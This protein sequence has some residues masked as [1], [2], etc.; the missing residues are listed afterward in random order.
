[1]QQLTASDLN[2]VL[3]RTPRDILAQLKQFPGILFLAGGFI[4]ATIAGEKVSDIDL[5]G[6]TESFCVQQANALA[7]KRKARVHK[8]NNAITVLAPPRVPVQYITRWTFS[9]P[10][11]LVSSFDFT[12]CQAAIW[13]DKVEVKAEGVNPGY[14]FRS[15]I[16]DNFYPDLAARRL[17]YTQ[18]KRI[19][20]TGGSLMRAFKFVKKGYNIQAPSIAGLVARTI[21]GVDMRAVEKSVAIDGGTVEERTA[22]VVMGLLRQVDPLVVI[23]GVDFVDE[24]QT[25]E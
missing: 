16:C 11:E 2:F 14:K 3:T 12:I 7:V 13:A 9:G 22:F 10:A 15:L 1:M 25:I 17:V 20:E 8:T 6:P 19:E 5:F 18:P 4:R 24:H 23:D 21:S